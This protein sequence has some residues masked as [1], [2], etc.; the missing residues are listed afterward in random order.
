MELKFDTPVSNH[1][2]LFVRIFMKIY[3]IIRCLNKNYLFG[4][5]ILLSPTDL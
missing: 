3:V 2:P 5:S 4:N 1:T